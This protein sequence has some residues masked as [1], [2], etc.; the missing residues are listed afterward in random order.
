MSL[1]RLACALIA[2]SLVACHSKS[3]GPADQEDGGDWDD[4][5]DASEV[6]PPEED[7]AAAPEPD[8]AVD[9]SVSD[10]T[11]SGPTGESDAEPNLWR[12]GKDFD[13]ALPVETTDGLGVLIDT[14][15]ANQ[16]DYFSFQGE[17][18]KFYELKTDRHSFSPD[19][20]LK[21]F[22]SDR[23]A[24]AENDDGS[25]WPGDAIDAR[26]LVEVTKSGTYYVSVQDPYTNAAFFSSS[27]SL[28]YYHLNVRE[29]TPTTKGFALAQGAGTTALSFEHDDKTGNDYVTVLG[30]LRSDESV[31]TFE[32]QADKALIGQSA[33]AG[34]KGNGSTFTGG[35]VRVAS[36]S[37]VLADIDRARGQASIHPPIGAGSHTVSISSV[38]VTRGD[39][40]YYSVDLVQ[41]KDNPSEQAEAANMTLA[42]AEPLT[43][44]GTTSR[45]GLLLARL[46]V[47]DVDYFR[48]DLNA[49]EVMR[50]TCEG[51]SGGSGVRELSAEFRDSNDVKI[52]SAQETTDRNLVLQSVAVEK[53]DSYY[54]R[55][56]ASVQPTPPSVERWVRCAILIN[57]LQ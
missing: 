4:E 17:A 42:G 20:V 34:P 32:G 50:G 43:F 5:V 45:R 54:L 46:P 13:D 6:E 23:Q 31:F 38:G 40:P 30:E 28:L 18:G 57:R 52:S 9:A 27:F 8:D 16:V 24:L 11:D 49:S 14:T 56:S 39:R 37:N 1:A 7:A 12:G 26:L 15:N 51:E 10:V 35:H 22:D 25:L 2:V 36:A 55:L 19:N 47:N 21:L 44:T 53:A 3:H 33:V 48:I 41:L 29:I